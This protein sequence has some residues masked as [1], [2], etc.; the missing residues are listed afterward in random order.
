M[1]NQKLPKLILD[2]HISILWRNQVILLCGNARWFLFTIAVFLLE[3][4][5]MNTVY[6]SLQVYDVTKEKPRRAQCFR[7]GTV[8]RRETCAHS[9][10]SLC[11]HGHKLGRDSGPQT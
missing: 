11:A 7:H 1:G 6:T 3:L 9:R 8:T 10:N 4:M 5:K 2:S